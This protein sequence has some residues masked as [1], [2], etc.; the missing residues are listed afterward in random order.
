MIV[1]KNKKGHQRVMSRINCKRL[2][3]VFL[4]SLVVLSLNFGFIDVR[5]SEAIDLLEA[6]RRALQHDAVYAAALAEKKATETY[7]QQGLAYL[8]PSLDARGSFSSYRTD[9]QIYGNYNTKSYGVTLRQPLFN[10]GRY[11]EYGQNNLRVE[12]GQLAFE[13]ASQDLILRTAS[14]YLDVLSALD[15]LELIQIEKRAVYERMNQATKIYEAGVGTIT[16]VNDAKARYNLLLAN[17][18]EAQNTFDVKKATFRKVVGVEPTGIKKLGDTLQLVSPVPETVEG[19]IDLARHNSPYLKQYAKNVELYEYEVKKSSSQFYPTLDLVFD[20]TTTDTKEYYRTT[21]ITYTSITAQLSMSLFSGG[22]T[23]AKVQEM[24]QRKKKA[25]EE[26]QEVLRES[27]KRIN[28]AFLGVKSS[29]AKVKAFELAVKSAQEALHSNEKGLIAGIRTIVD[30]LNA[31]H[32]LYDAKR[33]ATNA[34][35]EYLIKNLR[36]RYEAGILSEDYLTEINKHLI[37][38]N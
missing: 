23:K 2:Q 1:L 7:K 26:Y 22:Y 13:T 3:A 12:L 24:T 4:F 8:L 25:S 17:E 29:I 30:V 33:K 21:P 20:R 28:D 6:Y 18:I 32:Q 31:Q 16:D 27:E 15:D 35:Y 37:S 14:V 19:W 9:S 11:A 38:K 36:L 5:P 10:L 34:K